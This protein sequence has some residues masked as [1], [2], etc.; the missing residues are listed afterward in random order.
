M[1]LST[2]M[3]GSLDAGR[4]RTLVAPW[5]DNPD[6]IAAPRRVLASWCRAN[7]LDPA[8]I[9]ERDGIEI[10]GPD[11]A[12]ASSRY[13]IMYREVVSQPEGERSRYARTELR[14]VPLVVEPE[15]LLADELTCGHVL[16]HQDT[17]D[18]APAF[19]TCDRHVDPA[20]GRHPGPHTGGPSEDPLTARPMPASSPF[21]ARPE[22]P[23]EVEGDQAFFAGVPYAGDMAPDRAHALVLDR[24]T[25]IADHRPRANRKNILVAIGVHVRGL[26]ALATRH[27]PVIYG[28]AFPALCRDPAHGEPG[29][30]FPCADYRD[31]LAGVVTFGPVTSA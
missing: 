3:V 15:G 4:V 23:N 10:H 9:L 19:Y 8:K 1:T 6:A 13:V 12:G 5:S 29:E 31:A 14:E 22:W 11:P 7:G 18:A 20:N 17:V 2:G 24:L 21:G 26:R 16:H 28:D 25:A 27:A 30:T